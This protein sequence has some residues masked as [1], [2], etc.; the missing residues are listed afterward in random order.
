M[1]NLKDFPVPDVSILRSGS[2]VYDW[3]SVMVLFQ[4]AGY[5]VMWDSRK[6]FYKYSQPFPYELIE[7]LINS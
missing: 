5:F 7:L 4:N 6:E 1:R 2:I 3:D